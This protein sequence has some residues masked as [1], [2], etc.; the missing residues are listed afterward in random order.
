VELTFVGLDGSERRAGL[1]HCQGV[2]FEGVKPVRELRSVRGQS[3][4]P[5]SWWFS[6][7]GDHVGFE[8]WLERD[9]LMMLDADPEVAAV[10]SQPFWLAWPD[11]RRRVRHAPDFF[12]RRS[13]GS[14]VV[15]DVRADD[16]IEPEDAIKFEVT[17]TAC[18][19][20]GWEYRR[21]GV[22]EPVLAANLRW[23]SGYRHPRNAAG[24]RAPEVLGTFTGP[25]A[26][27]EGARAAGDPIAVLPLVFH[28]LWRRILLADLSASVLG[29]GSVV[30]AAGERS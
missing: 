24:D 18:A 5:G 25:V 26:L 8:S 9:V 1:L 2:P 13:G 23:L 11:G 12:A 29:P 6:R 19:S 28:L 14:A 3:H 7:T 10:S 27:M 30:W 21:I 16:R 4:F 15:I 20:A 22:L 17:A